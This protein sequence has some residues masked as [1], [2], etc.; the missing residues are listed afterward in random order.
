MAAPFVGFAAGAFKVAA[1]AAPAVAQAAPAVA[2]SSPVQC[3]HG[4]PCQRRVS[5]TASNP[6]RAFF[7]CAREPRSAQCNFFQWEDEAVQQ[8]A[9]ST[10]PVEE[11]M[12]AAR[13]RGWDAKP[14]AQ[15]VSAAHHV[16]VEL[17][18]PEA[19]AEAT[20]VYVAPTGADAHWP[21]TLEL[22]WHC[23]E[24]ACGGAL[25]EG[26]AHVVAVQQAEDGFHL[27]R[28]ASLAARIVASRRMDNEVRIEAVRSNKHEV[29]A[30]VPADMLATE[31]WGEG[32]WGNG[33]QAMEQ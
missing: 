6:N 27:F 1:Q 13:E 18:R 24:A 3:K 9:P 33:P 29:V 25:Q 7:K 4:E 28:R 12:A 32:W 11:F 5:N 16:H 8:V 22:Q 19:P 20:L 10:V 17:R 2:P 15:L 30:H 21:R 31:Q 23:A 14:I 26:W